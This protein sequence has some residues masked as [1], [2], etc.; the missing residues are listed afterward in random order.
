MQFIEIGEKAK[1]SQIGRV[2]DMA[3]DELARGRLACSD[4]TRVKCPPE[5]TSLQHNSEICVTRSLPLK[6]REPISL[7]LP[8]QGGTLK[9][10]E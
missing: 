6:C 3:V 2:A 1:F 5:H 7:D 9:W 10:Q 8:A 4:L